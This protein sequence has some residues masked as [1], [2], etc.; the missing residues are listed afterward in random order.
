MVTA[1]CLLYLDRNGAVPL[2]LIVT[3]FDKAINL[4]RRAQSIKPDDAYPPAQIKK[5]EEA[6]MIALNKDKTQ[7]E[8][9]LLIK[10]GKRDFEGKKLG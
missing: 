4:Y 3:K 2:S 5:V 8:F 9:G 6:K 7:Q 10:E 1:F